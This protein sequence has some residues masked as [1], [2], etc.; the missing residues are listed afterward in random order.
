M[1]RSKDGH[2]LGKM[3]EHLDLPFPPE[4][5]L[6]L[7]AVAAV[8]GAASE[9]SPSP[10]TWARD[11]LE[12]AIEGNWAMRNGIAIPDRHRELWVAT[13]A[14]LR[15]MK[16]DEWKRVELDKRIA[17]EWVFITRR[18]GL[19]PALDQSEEIRNLS[20]HSDKPGS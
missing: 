2:P 6:R 1:A 15:G 12:K 20:R 5:K 16:P 9:G 8:A 18:V 14:T 11:E 13:I 19:T 3:T 10:T 7:N 4:L 17:G